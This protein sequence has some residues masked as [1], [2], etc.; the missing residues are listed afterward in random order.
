MSLHNRLLRNVSAEAGARLLYLATR[1]FIPPFV[2]S[3][4]GMEAYGF[5]GAVFVLVAYFGM[6]AIGFS[7]A[8]IKYLA[9]F[10][11][12]G[13]HG[14]ANRLLSSGFTLMTAVSAFCFCG[15]AVS[16]PWLSIWL[17][18][19]VELATPAKILAFEI[20]GIF[21]VYLTLSVFRDALTSQ[22][23]IAAVQKIWI[24][25]FLLE[26]VL[27]FALVGN[28][29]G[30]PGLGAAFVLRTLLDVVAHYL[31][32]RR[33]IPWLR[34][35]L[36]KPDRE[37]IQLLMRFGGIV[38]LNCLLS[39]FLNSIERV[40][41]TPLLGLSASALLDIGKRLPSMG[42]SI[43]SA[44]ASSVYPAAAELHA[45]RKGAEQIASLYLSTTRIMNATS[46]LLFAF[47]TFAAA[48]CL[49]FWLGK[50]PDGAV[51]LTILFAISS[52]MH[53]LTGPGTSI[54]KAMG[55]PR[56]EFHYSLTNLLALIILVPLSNFL[57]GSWHVVA[58]ASACAASTALS[59]TWFLFRAHKQLEISA[60][61][62]ARRAFAPGLLP[63]I[64]GAICLAPFMHHAVAGSRLHAMA[65]LA[66][67]GL[68]F[69]T[70]SSLLSF[71][72]LATQEERETLKLKLASLQ[73][74]FFVNRSIVGFP[75][76]VFEPK[77]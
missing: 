73:A 42:T 23:D 34:V 17:K 19:P 39:I 44:F 15:F 56:M 49:F 7:S 54:L 74:R 29:C 36:A 5:Y 59:A 41:A 70:L 14:K 46:G 62:F 71:V 24:A 26:T 10:A 55:N 72:L 67:A 57:A 35:G 64:V 58:I 30:L 37:S 1:F 13:E 8:Y 68:F 45:N 75:P 3:H 28:G 43:P 11:A 4:I 22:Q 66:G 61:V 40:I 20:V 52:Q 38:Q 32:A 27:I 77:Q 18:V 48:P 6:S 65:V 2:L 12:S 31:L 63:Y 47:L 16:W 50:V 33:R 53:L 69:L 60:E 25:S 51:A 9:E 21:F 76:H